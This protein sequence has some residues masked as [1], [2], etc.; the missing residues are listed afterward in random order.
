MKPLIIASKKDPAGMNIIENLK[1]LNCKFPIYLTDKEI[2]H[3]ENIDEELEA[4][5]IIFA[6][7]HQSEK[8]FNSLTVHTVGNFGEAKFGGKIGKICPA[9]SKITK[10]FFQ[11]LFKNSK[12]L[13][14][15]VSLETTHHGPLI[16]T[17]CL[18]IE[19]GS[20]LT[21]WK[22]KTAGKII[23]QTILDSLSS[24]QEKSYKTAIG[25]GGPHYCPNFNKIQLQEKYA[26]SHII[27][28]YNLP[29]TSSMIK[30]AISKTKEK[31][32]ILI[33]DWKGLGNSQERNSQLEILKEF[34]LPIIK[35][36]EAKQ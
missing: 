8:S 16:K 14:Y 11:T 6:S 10:H 33:I 22:D 15:Q 19:I 28:Q 2:I 17:P 26:L 36:K 24:F 27:P 9:S 30:E 35:T 3:A 12:N 1:S 31:I 32:E 13:D 18:F 23:A 21:Q 29:L 7:K 34:N 5:F 20:S 25:I 4:D